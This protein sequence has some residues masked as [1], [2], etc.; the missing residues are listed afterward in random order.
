MW[1]VCLLCLGVCLCVCLSVRVCELP[2]INFTVAPSSCTRFLC[3]NAKVQSA[4][5]K[6]EYTKNE[7]KE[8]LR[9][10]PSEISNVLGVYKPVVLFTDE[11]ERLLQRPPQTSGL[12]LFVAEY[13]K[14]RY[15]AY[16]QDRVRAH[17]KRLGD[18]TSLAADSLHEI[19]PSRSAGVMGWW[20]CD[21][22][23]VVA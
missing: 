8:Q 9:L 3:L 19:T 18:G 5:D 11:L 6:D 23:V 17:V 21:V 12:R 4:E 13:V 20:W 7:S 14:Q 1:N 22:V 2:L 16:L 15:L 10:C